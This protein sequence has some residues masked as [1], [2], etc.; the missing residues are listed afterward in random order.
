MGDV[1]SVVFLEGTFVKTGGE[2]GCDGN[3]IGFGMGWGLVVGGDRYRRGD[4]D[5]VKAASW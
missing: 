2:M 1:K 3:N 5:E 4:V